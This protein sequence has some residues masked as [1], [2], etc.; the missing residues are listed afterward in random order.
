MDTATINTVV[1]VTTMLSMLIL[2]ISMFKKNMNLSLESAIMMSFFVS[3]IPTTIILKDTTF[4]ASTNFITMQISTMN[5]YTTTTTN[6]NSNLFLTIAL[7]VT[8]S[9]MQFSTWYMKEDTKVKM[10]KNFLMIFLIAMLILIMAG[11]LFQLFIGW[12]GVGIM[13]F[14]LINWWYARTYANSSA[15]Q[16]MIYNRIGDIGIILILSCLA[17]N[18][19]TWEMQLI[20]PK[21]KTTLMT[22]GLILAAAGKSAQFFMHMWLPSAMEGPTPVSA[23]LHSSTMVVAGVYLL[24]QIHPIISNSKKALIICACLGATTSLYASMAALS[25][26]DMKKIIA[27]STLSQL[28][29]MLIAIGLNHPKLALLHI[30][31]HAATKAALFLCAGSLIHNLQNEQDI[32]KMGNMKIMMPITT[33]CLLI[34]S[35]ALMGMPFMSCF[36]SKDPIIEMLYSSKINMWIL[37]MTMMATTATSTYSMRMMFYTTMKSA[38]NKS[39]MMFKE[40]SNQVNPIIRLTALSITNGVIMTTLMKMN[41]EPMMPMLMKMTPL[42][43]IAI[44][45]LLTMETLDKPTHKLNYKNLSYTFFNQLAFFKTLHRWTPKNTLKTGSLMAT[46]LMDLM[47]LEKIGPKHINLTNK[48]T[49]KLINPLTGMTKTYLSTFAISSTLALIFNYTN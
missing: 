2:P 39:N 9:I 38:R 12:E 42:M 13:S 34:T 1:V 31:T 49:S 40:S 8:W 29:L 47:W 3:L 20:D 48:M 26:N 14:L 21:I 27:L 24:I 18:Q 37:I 16:A 33:S 28:G 35:L 32:R 30:S 11:S 10:F 43:A 36:Y 4:N 17:I 22:T 15:M 7:F 6:M 19:T 25:Q 41:I 5:I 44:G 23:L 45:T 46:Q